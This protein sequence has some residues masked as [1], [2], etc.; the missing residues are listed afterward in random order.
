MHAGM[1]GIQNRP[2]QKTFL[3][4]YLIGLKFCTVI[5]DVV[6][7]SN[8]GYLISRIMKKHNMTISKLKKKCDKYV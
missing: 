7:F 1:V 5:D 4:I 8:M 2:G 3:A 6:F